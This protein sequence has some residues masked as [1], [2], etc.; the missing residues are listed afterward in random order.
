M[1]PPAGQGTEPRPVIVGYIDRAAP[2]VVDPDIC[3]ARKPAS[4]AFGRPPRGTDVVRERSADPAAEACPSSTTADG[5]PAVG[6]SP[7]VVE[8][9]AA[10]G[11]A[12]AAGPADLGEAIRD[13]L[14]QDHVARPRDEP[15]TERRP[16]RRP[17]V[18]RD[19]DLV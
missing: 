19:D 16:C 2:G 15:P 18:E 9:E 11:Q 1:N 12:F 10:I 14:C 17:G 13:R 3:Q 7:G 6:R 5:D 4:Q 8:G